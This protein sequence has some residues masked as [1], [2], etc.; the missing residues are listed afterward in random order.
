MEDTQ[1]PNGKMGTQH[2]EDKITIQ[3]DKLNKYITPGPEVKGS[4]LLEVREESN[5]NMNLIKLKFKDEMIE[6]QK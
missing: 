6:L 5:R 1:P 3:L 2:N 4:P